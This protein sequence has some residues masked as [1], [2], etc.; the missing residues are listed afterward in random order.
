MRKVCGAV[1]AE[2]RDFNGQ[3]DHAH[4]LAGYPPKV[5]DPA[6]VNS[7]RR[8]RPASCDRSSPAR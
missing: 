2:L 5:T 7:P 1:G 8:C 4:L 3:D 6:P